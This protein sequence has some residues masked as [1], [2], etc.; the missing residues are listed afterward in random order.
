MEYSIVVPVYNSAKTLPILMLE[1]ENVMVKL[2]C[3][4]EIVFVDDCSNDQSWE[5]LKHLSSQKNNIKILKLANNVGQWMATLAGIENA[6]GKHIITIDDDLEYDSNDIEKL[7][8]E[9]KKENTYIVYGIPIEKKNKNLSYKL[10]F[11]T[12]DKFLRIF[13]GK[14]K[15]ESFK[16][17]KREIYF[18]DTKLMTSHIHFEAY[19]KFTVA[20]KYIKYIDVN[21]RKRFA[22]N[23]NHTLYMKA[24]LMFKYGIEYYKSPFKY[25]LY[26]LTMFL[27]LLLWGMIFSINSIFIYG[28]MALMTLTFLLIIGILGKYLSA[29]YFKL[30]GLPEYIIIGRN[31]SK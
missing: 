20:E 6:S 7:I 19:T 29:I 3:E 27:L 13:L 16:I 23:S 5:T 17:F 22:G 14:I 31:E 21:Y 15:T 1:L 25:P 30:K 10:F 18:K 28:I 2:N 9:Y 26:F 11:K 8:K 24:K 4:F 12:R